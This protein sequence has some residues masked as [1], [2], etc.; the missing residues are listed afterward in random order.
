MKSIISFFFILYLLGFTQANTKKLLPLKDTKI[1]ITAE[2]QLPNPNIDYCD[3]CIQFMG[4]AIDQLL[5]IIL[6]IGVIGGCADLCGYLNNQLEVVVC[7]ML[8]D[9]VGIEEFIQLVNDEDPD[10]IWLCEEMDACP[11]NDNAA[12]NITSASV[13]PKQGHKGDQFQ[14][15][16]TA[17]ITNAIG[18]GE[19]AFEIHPVSGFPLGEGFL[20]ESLQPG[21]YKF[22]F[23]WRAE[24]VKEQHWSPGVYNITVA[25]CEGACGSPHSHSFTLSEVKH[26]Q[27]QI[28][29]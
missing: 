28:L 13:V 18:T 10:P 12:G 24:P 1:T 15:F 8:C 22:Q 26:V 2:N 20:L 17:Q 3:I 9:Y 5:N 21:N 25:I 29:K 14:L 16:V 4:Q 23:H 27:F 6:N 7:D 11:V 19:I